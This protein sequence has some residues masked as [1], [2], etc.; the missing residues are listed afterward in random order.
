MAVKPEIVPTTRWR[1]VGSCAMTPGLSDIATNTKPVKSR[2]CP[3]DGDEVVVPL[4]RSID[5]WR[6]NPP[7][8][9]RDVATV[10]LERDRGRLGTVATTRVQAVDRGGLLGR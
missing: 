1:C 9:L 6:D 2:G 8:C 4:V 7:S 10:R 3:A 5:V